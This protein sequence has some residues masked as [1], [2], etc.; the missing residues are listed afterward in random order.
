MPASKSRFAEELSAESKAQL[1]CQLS[2]TEKSLKAV[3][4]TIASGLCAAASSPLLA[5]AAFPQ[6][7]SF[8][9]CTGAGLQPPGWLQAG[10]SGYAVGCAGGQGRTGAWSSVIQ[11]IPGHGDFGTQMQ[12]VSA[13]NYIGGVSINAYLRTEGL[14]SGSWAGVWGRVD[15]PNGA[16]LAFDN[17]SNRGVVGTTAWAPYGVTLSVP[18]TA[19]DICF[20]Y[21]LTGDGTA[22]ADD[23]YMTSIP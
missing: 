22:W 6:D 13:A 17:M 23:F 11:S 4:L 21:L 8:S 16:L 9:G 14:T 3:I 1:P 2:D 18:P 15:G 20:G 5:Q 19:V 10:E 12:C 7:L